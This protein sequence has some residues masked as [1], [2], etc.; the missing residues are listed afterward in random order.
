MDANV[1]LSLHEVTLYITQ[2]CMIE[3]PPDEDTPY[4]PA[5]LE[6]CHGKHCENY[7]VSVITTICIERLN[8]LIGSPDKA[9]QVPLV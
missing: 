6:A 2:M 4:S 9:I 1:L 3:K 8:R 7:M 5:R